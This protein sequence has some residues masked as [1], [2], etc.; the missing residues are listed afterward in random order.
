MEE[1]FCFHCHSTVLVDVM[2]D[3]CPRCKASD[4]VIPVEEDDAPFSQPVE[5]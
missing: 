5:R 3:I 4:T 1:C 2:A